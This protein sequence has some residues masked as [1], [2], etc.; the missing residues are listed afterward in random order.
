M[1]LSLVIASTI[2]IFHN[3]SGKIRNFLYIKQNHFFKLP[4]IELN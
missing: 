1:K 3:L 2:P 4:L